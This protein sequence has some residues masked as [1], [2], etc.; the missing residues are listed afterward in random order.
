MTHEALEGAKAAA[1]IHQPGVYFGL[2][3]DIYHRDPALGSTDIKTLAFSPCDYWF[4]SPLNPDRPDAESTPAQLFGSAVHKLVL[5]GRQAFEGRYAATEHNGSTKAGKAERAEIEEAGKIAIRRDDFDRIL[6]AGATV[7]ANTVL[8][9]AFSGGMP[10]VSIFW[11]AGG[12]RRKC[13]ID[14][15]KARASVDLKSIRNTRNI[16]FAQACRRAISDFRYDVQAQHYREGREALAGLVA[17]GAVFGD[18]DASWL[19]RLARAPAA[20]FVFVFYQAEGA[21]LSYG[22][23][24]SPENP[25]LAIARET[26]DLAEANFVTFRDRYGL[27]RPWLLDEP[28]AELDLA[29]MPAWFART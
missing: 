19:A 23:V 16:G 22:T 27:D 10:E 15:L 20:A 21:P 25:I 13:R 6:A 5:E 14:Y 18:H 1:I 2:A 29:D 4:K 7:A 3:D 24:L 28:L 8:A 12:I 26:I 17:D 9:D 11:E